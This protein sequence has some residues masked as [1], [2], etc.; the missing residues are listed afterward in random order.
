MNNFNQTYKKIKSIFKMITIIVFL[1]S[2]INTQEIT[3]QNNIK[4]SD[5]T[6][7]E[8]ISTNSSFGIILIS[9]GKFCA[10]GV[11]GITIQRYSSLKND[12]ISYC[13]SKPKPISFC[14]ITFSNDKLYISHETLN[15]SYRKTFIVEIDSDLII[16][17]THIYDTVDV[18]PGYTFTNMKVS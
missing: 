10:G 14:S 18:Y 6:P 16:L 15:L 5:N 9:Q 13:N 3:I 2:K 12:S 8:F 17:L 11:T 1:I 4:T 7:R